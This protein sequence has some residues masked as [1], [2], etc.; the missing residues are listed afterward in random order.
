MMTN[1]KSDNL[2]KDLDSLFWD[3]CDPCSAEWCHVY[4]SIYV[5]DIQISVLQTNNMIT[6]NSP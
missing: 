2:Q 3:H 1:S 5:C 4:Y 6:Q